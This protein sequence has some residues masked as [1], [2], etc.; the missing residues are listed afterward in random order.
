MIEV[1]GVFRSHRKRAVFI[2]RTDAIEYKDHLD[3][4]YPIKVIWNEFE[5]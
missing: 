2:N 4:H 5:L 3:A 1:V